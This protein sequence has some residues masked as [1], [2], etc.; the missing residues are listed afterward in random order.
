MRAFTLTNIFLF[1]LAL[2]FAAG[3]GSNPAKS[4]E[5]LD[6]KLG[7]AFYS[8]NKYKVGEEVLR[9]LEVETMSRDPAFLLQDKEKLTI[10]NYWASWCSGCITEL[11][12]L[13]QFQGKNPDVRVI[14]VGDNKNGFEAIKKMADQYGLPEENSYYDSRGYIKRWL[15]VGVYPTTLVV[16]PTGD[17]LYRFEG[18]SDWSKPVMSELVSALKTEHK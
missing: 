4:E 14:Y 16:S 11:P 12:T 5:S 1:F 6:K 15:N 7:K 2:I 3:A 9:T 10:I 13:T 17:I 8:V 18:D